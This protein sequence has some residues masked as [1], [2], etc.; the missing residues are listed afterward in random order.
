VLHLIEFQQ[1][2]RLLSYSPLTFDIGSP[3][4]AEYKYLHSAFLLVLC[5][6]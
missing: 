6:F 3:V 1:G 4:S 2:S 5:F